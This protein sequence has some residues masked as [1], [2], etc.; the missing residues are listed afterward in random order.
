MK[1][2]AVYYASYAAV[3]PVTQNHLMED[4]GSLLEPRA[5]R[6]PVVPH[7][8]ANQH[9]RLQRSRATSGSAT[10][11]TGSILTAPRSPNHAIAV[12]KVTKVTKVTP[13]NHGT[14]VTSH[15]AQDSR[16]ESRH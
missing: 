1:G 3:L 8:A 2:K 16:H 7:P 4:A 11:A 10:T 9:H 14:E 5:L 15:V 12:T 13:P 6:R